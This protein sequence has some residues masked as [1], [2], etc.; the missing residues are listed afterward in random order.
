[1]FKFARGVADEISKKLQLI[2]WTIYGLKKSNR[3][4]WRPDS[5]YFVAGEKSPLQ[6]ENVSFQAFWLHHQLKNKQTKNKQ[7]KKRYLARGWFGKERG[8]IGQKYEIITDGRSATKVALNSKCRRG[9]MSC[10]VQEG[11]GLFLIWNHLASDPLWDD[12][13]SPRRAEFRFVGMCLLRAAGCRLQAAGCSL[14]RVLQVKRPD[15]PKH[16]TLCPLARF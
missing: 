11:E 4:Q 10:S 5:L 8:K 9:L 13:Q 12:H 16:Q 15:S 1:M 7:E 3:R 2:K 6:K 14:S